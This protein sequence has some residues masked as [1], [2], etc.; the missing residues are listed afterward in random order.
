MDR[1]VGQVCDRTAMG[2]SQ[3]ASSTLTQAWDKMV[4]GRFPR[5]GDTL[6][7]TQGTSRR[8]Q[9]EEVKTEQAEETG[10]PGLAEAVGV[11]ADGGSVSLEPNSARPEIGQMVKAK[12]VVRL[13]PEKVFSRKK[14]AQAYLCFL[15]TLLCLCLATAQHSGP[16]ASLAAFP[17]GQGSP[18]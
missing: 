8:E 13:C 18:H 1:C 3:L 6:A 17:K 14:Q 2:T 12:G 11:G 16:G 10:C 5:G 4:Q 15:P 7:E 9:G